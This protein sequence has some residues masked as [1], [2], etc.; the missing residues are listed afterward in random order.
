MRTPFLLVCL[1]LSSAAYSQSGYKLPPEDIV[2][3][4]DA[5]PTPLV[6]IDPTN[7]RMA[8]VAYDAQPSLKLIARPIHRI[9]GIRIDGARHS[10]QRTRQYTGIEVVTI[11]T[12]A[13]TTISIPVY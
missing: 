8:L 6:T 11:R 5:P 2:R 4:V 1:F 12:G 13:R 10:R 9:A 3:I 7:T